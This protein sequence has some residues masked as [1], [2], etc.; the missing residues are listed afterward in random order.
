M[1]FRNFSPVYVPY[2]E[3]DWGVF[4]RRVGTHLVVLAIHVD[5]CLIT[6]SSRRLLDDSKTKINSSYA[7][8]DMG[9]VSWL[10]GIRVV[11]DAEAGTLALSQHAY[12][13]AILARFN[14]TDLKPVSTPMDPHARLS[15]SQCP[16]SA[17]E[18][19]RMRRYPY[20]EAIGALMYAAMGTRPD[21]AFAVST[22]AQFSGNPG[23]PHW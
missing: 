22:L 7:M 19:A 4:S 13:D 21:I 11:R 17:A 2:A 16:E 10:L 1:T 5:D 8:T 12:I 20:R 14:F 3:A 9:P 23:E 6:G 15:K 18:V